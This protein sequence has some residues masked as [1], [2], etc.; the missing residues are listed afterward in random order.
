MSFHEVLMKNL[1]ED[2]LKIFDYLLYGV[3]DDER[4]IMK[5]L[6]SF[7]QSY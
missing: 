6:K 7:V 4:S 5:V 3:R 2:Q 1:P